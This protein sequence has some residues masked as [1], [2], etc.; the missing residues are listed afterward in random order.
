MR[1]AAIIAGAPRPGR[2]AATAAA[3]LFALAA[4][5][6]SA[7]PSADSAASRQG[8]APDA[9]ATAVAATATAVPGEPTLVVYKTPTCG[10]CRGWVS[11]MEKAGFKVETHDVD[12]LAP[13]KHAAGVPDELQACHTARIGGYVVEG[14]VPAADIRRLLAERPDIAGIAAP[15]MP[16][17]SPGMEGGSK[18]PYDVVTF[19]GSARS[20]VYASH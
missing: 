6:T 10:C 3:T 8:A 16:M 18:E 4:C 1:I 9:P 14:H 7:R 20:T 5:S 13:T 17:G 15:G 19:G 2:L 12:D 11:A